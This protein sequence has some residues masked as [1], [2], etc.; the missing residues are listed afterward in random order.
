MG[1][2]NAITT[3]P[4]GDPVICTWTFHIPLDNTFSNIHF[5][6]GLTLLYIQNDW[7][8]IT[9][10]SVEVFY[11]RV[12]IDSGEQPASY[13]MRTGGCYPGDKVAGAW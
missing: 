11:H 5:Y 2:G 1:R 4:R 13:P 6:L 10:V 9:I 7:C 8:R 3:L 12:Q